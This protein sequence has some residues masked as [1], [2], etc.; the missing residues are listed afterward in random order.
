[1]DRRDRK[2]IAASGERTLSAGGRPRYLSLGLRWLVRLFLALFIAIAITTWTDLLFNPVV[3]EHLIGSEHACAIHYALCSW[4]SYILA[5]L[6]PTSLL[7]GAALV[8]LVW[9]RLRR[10]ET[11]LNILALLA[12]LYLAWSAIQVQLAE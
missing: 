7:A 3:S 5:E 1:M 10:R 11:I 9:R 6:L 12:F 4:R 8:T 2:T